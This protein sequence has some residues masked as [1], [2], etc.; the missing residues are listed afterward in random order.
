MTNFLF[1]RRKLNQL[2]LSQKNHFFNAYGSSFMLC[3]GDEGDYSYTS[4]DPTKTEPT[5]LFRRS[6]GTHTIRAFLVSKRVPQMNTDVLKII[7]EFL[8]DY[9]RIKDLR[10]TDFIN[11]CLTCR[12]WRSIA[13]PYLKTQQV[14]GV[15]GIYPDLI[16]RVGFQNKVIYQ[17]MG[18]AIG[19]E[20]W[21]G[22]RREFL[23]I[24]SRIPGTSQ[25]RRIDFDNCFN[26]FHPFE[27]SRCLRRCFNLQSFSFRGRKCCCEDIKLFLITF[28]TRSKV[29]LHL[30]S[31][32]DMPAQGIHCE[33]VDASP[34]NQII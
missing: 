28:Q 34:H 11:L 19:M 4:F 2:S 21:A 1:Q 3:Y 7:F 10:K 15:D 27:W 18:K 25:L 5:K 20:A 9:L 26:T 29:H 6:A 17:F 16:H 32:D 14:L 22:Y 31:L 23:D 12:Y 8:Y 30:L 33:S 13:Q 24:L